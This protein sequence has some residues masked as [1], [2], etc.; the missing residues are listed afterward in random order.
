MFKRLFARPEPPPTFSPNLGGN[1]AERLLSEMR[2]CINRVGGALTNARR[3]NALADLFGKLTPAGQRQFI[4]VLKR[5]DDI[6]AENTADRY[7]QIEEAE[8][9]GRSSSKLAILDAFE[10]P[11]KR[12]LWQLQSS[13]DGAKAI[14]G[15]REAGD[16]S[17]NEIIDNL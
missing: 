17:L 12:M 13:R 5:L 14:A 3:A 16:R 2:D 6:G 11:V 4:A 1:D 8:L 10:S 9:F 7:S 15:I